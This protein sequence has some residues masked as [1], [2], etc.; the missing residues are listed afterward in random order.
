MDVFSLFFS[1]TS[2]MSVCK[3][4]TYFFIFFPLRSKASGFIHSSFFALRILY[5]EHLLPGLSPTLWGPLL[6]GALPQPTPRRRRRRRKYLSYKLLISGINR[7]WP[8]VQ[9][10]EDKQQ[11]SKI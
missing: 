6:D 10:H 1:S 7:D 5:Q 3:N 2:K 11:N 4:N 8:S 9:G